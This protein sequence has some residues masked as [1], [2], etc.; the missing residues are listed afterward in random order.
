MEYVLPTDIVR[1]SIRRLQQSKLQE[2]FIFYLSILRLKAKGVDLDE[3]DSS[4][5]QDDLIQWLRVD[6]G[7]FPTEDDPRP[8]Y[9]PFASRGSSYWMNPNLAGSFAWSSLRNS[10][11]TLFYTQDKKLRLPNQSEVVENLTKNKKVDAVDIASYLFR[12]CSFKTG[13]TSPQVKDLI[14]PFKTYFG[15]KDGDGFEQIFDFSGGQ[16]AEALLEQTK[17]PDNSTSAELEIANDHYRQL[18]ADELGIL[19]P[20]QPQQSQTKGEG[21]T[22]IMAEKD[23]GDQTLR[24]IAETLD[25]YSGVILSGAPGTSKSYYARLAAEMITSDDVSRMAFVQ[26]HASYQFEDFIQGYRPDE[27]NGGFKK[28]DGIFLRMC[29]RADQ[30]I[31]NPYVIVIDELSRGD[32]QRIFGEA[33]T[34]M[35]KTKRGLEFTLPSGD[36]ANIPR[37]I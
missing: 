17:T 26:F 15:I 33:L 14:P 21:L 19:E 13:K 28:V 11:K 29:K 2:Q 7:Q 31:D 25:D 8:Y 30:D 18:N 23:S 1:R 35:E 12:N 22:G 32:S 3:C 10:M 36:K 6:G 16:D 5:Y 37:N 27:K 9:R 24:E 4:A 34:Y 20:S